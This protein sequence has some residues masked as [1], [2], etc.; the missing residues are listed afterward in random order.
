MLFLRLCL[1]CHF[2]DMIADTIRCRLHH[3]F[4]D[5]LILD[6]HRFFERYQPRPTRQRQQQNQGGHE[7]KR[8]RQNRTGTKPTDTNRHE[9]RTGTNRTATN[10]RTG[11]TEP[12][13]TGQVFSFL[14]NGVVTKTFAPKFYAEWSNREFHSSHGNYFRDYFSFYASG[15]SLPPLTEP[16]EPANRVNRRTARTEPDLRAE[17]ALKTEP[18]QK[19]N[20]YEPR[21]S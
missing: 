8:K 12:K 13:Q 4:R 17:P 3:R 11:R 19:T 9:P 2:T 6:D 1:T 18:H 10:R 16:R 20:R 15:R 5:G 14:E 21:P 7:P